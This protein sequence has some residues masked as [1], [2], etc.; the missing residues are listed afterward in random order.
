[1][2]PHPLRGQS[3]PGSFEKKLAIESGIA[4]DKIN[5]VIGI[6]A[7]SYKLIALPPPGVRG[8]ALMEG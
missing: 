4:V 5:S 7:E 8:R 3:T 2:P 6:L 1:M